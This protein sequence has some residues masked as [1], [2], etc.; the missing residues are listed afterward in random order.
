MLYKD[1]MLDPI[2]SD[3]LRAEDKRKRVAV[4]SFAWDLSE[5]SLRPRFKGRKP[6]RGMPLW[7]TVNKGCTSQPGTSVGEP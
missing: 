1:P 7:K 6:S 5:A 4:P 3:S 2:H